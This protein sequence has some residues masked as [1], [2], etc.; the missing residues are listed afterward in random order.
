[1][2]LLFASF[3][4]FGQEF[5]PEALYKKAVPSVM[6]LKAGKKDG[7]VVLGS[8]FLITNSGIAATAWHVV[9]GATQVSARFSDGEEFEVSGLVDKDEKRDL[10]LIRVKI[11]GR[12]ELTVVGDDPQV[13]SRAYV[14]GAP[15]GLE[16][17]ISEGLLSQIQRIDNVKQYQFSSAASPGNSG[18]PLLNVAGQVIG[19]V[20]WQVKNGQNLNFAVP[21]SYLL[22]LDKTLPTLP[23][24]TVRPSTL[25]VAATTV[26]DLEKDK[27]LGRAYAA[28]ADSSA[29]LSFQGQSMSESN[30]Y[31]RGVDPWLYSS[32]REMIAAID[33]LK[34]FVFG[35]NYFRSTSTK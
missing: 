3:G 5:K 15:L 2:A 18:G 17:S 20:S 8:A 27:A 16:F 19:V 7:A 1:V 32:Q 23:W 6:T 14:I 22:G 10:A 21:S 34:D 12:P 29:A 31:R 25:P 35:P 9:N 4:V 30:A 24:D 33:P 13:G 28:I 11:F 26:T